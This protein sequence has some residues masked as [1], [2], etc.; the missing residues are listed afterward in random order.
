MKHLKS[1]NRIYQ[2]NYTCIQDYVSAIDEKATLISLMCNWNKAEVKRKTVEVFLYNLSAKTKEIMVNH[3]IYEMK[4]IVEYIS[5]VKQFLLDGLED[6]QRNKFG[7]PF[8]NSYTNQTL[9]HTK[10]KAEP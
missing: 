7:Q 3:D 9:Q 5:R 8:N 1:L 2:T 10:T 6:R 4:E